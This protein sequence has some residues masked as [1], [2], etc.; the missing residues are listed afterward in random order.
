MKQL[1]KRILIEHLIHINEQG[2]SKITTA[3]FIEKAQNIHG[4]RYD[5]SKSNYINSTTPVTIICNKHGEFKQKPHYHIKGSNCPKC[6]GGITTNDE[7]IEKAKGVHGDR[8]DYSKT[9]FTKVTDP[10][11]ITC[12]LHGDFTQNQAIYHL[13]GNG[14]PKCGKKSTT[15]EFIEKDKKIYG[16][17][18]DYSKVK[19]E[20][21]KKP[22]II[23]CPIHGDFKKTPH[24]HLLGQGCPKCSN[25]SKSN[26][27]EFIEKA[28][29]IHGDKYDYSKVDYENNKKPVTIIC[30]IHGEFN[31][32]PNTHLNGGGCYFCGKLKTGEKLK[33]NTESFI[34]AARKVYGVKYDYSKV[35][36][37]TS[38]SPVKIICPIHGEFE[39]IASYH[40]A[41]NGCKKCGS[42]NVPYTTEEYIQAAKEIHGD[43]YKYDDLNYVNA[44]TPV[45]ITCKKHGDFL[46]KPSNHLSGQ[47]CPKCSESRGHT[48]LRN[49][50]TINGIIFDEERKFED[51]TNKFK[52]RYCTKLPFDFYIPLKNT[53]IEYDGV[54]HFIPSFG[55]KS[56]EITKRNDKIKNQYCVKNGI[57]LIRIP[58][59]MKKEEIEPYILKEL[60]IK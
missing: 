25:T 5:Y 35:V 41:G 17:K 12:P 10:V 32:K 31:Q 49:I 20:L 23:N 44:Q 27:N 4:G 48:F 8:Y 42:R 3:D 43:R 7:F 39:Q 51:C 40:L 15:E 60:G 45:K 14:C 16:D 11:T 24:M 1:I 55:E 56:F 13:N 9:N 47:G 19:Y 52:G 38:K 50:L 22:V 36:Y 28:I 58:Y 2:K 54:Q 21:A 33:S 18:Y 26:T 53:I 6:R 34:D 59:T 46:Q 29:E 57:K 30:P 37:T